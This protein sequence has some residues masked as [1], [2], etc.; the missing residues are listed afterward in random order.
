[1]QDGS[2]AANAHIW[3]QTR[4]TTVEVYY[5]FFMTSA[6]GAPDYTVGGNFGHFAYN[7]VVGYSEGIAFTQAPQRG[8]APFI[9]EA[10][11]L[12]HTQLPTIRSDSPAPVISHTQT[13]TV[14]PVHVIDPVNISI[15]KAESGIGML[16]VEFFH[17]K[18]GSVAWTSTVLHDNI[19]PLGSNLSLSNRIK[20]TG[21]LTADIPAS[22][23]DGFS[24]VEYFIR[25]TDVSRNRTDSPIYTINYITST[26]IPVIN[27]ASMSNGLLGASYNESLL[28]F[29][30]APFTWSIRDG[31]LPG[32]LSLNAET[33]AIS[34]MPS[35]A[36]TFRF[37]AEVENAYGTDAREY[38]IIIY[39]GSAFTS[40][41]PDLI[42]TGISSRNEFEPLGWGSASSMGGYSGQ[43][44][45]VFNT[46]SQSIN[47][48]EFEAYYAKSSQVWV[49]VNPITKYAEADIA[50]GK[51]E[52]EEAWLPAYSVGVIW[53]KQSYQGITATTRNKTSAEFAIQMGI[54]ESLLF[55]AENTVR[56]IADT[57]GHAQRFYLQ[58]NAEGTRNEIGLVKKGHVVQDGPKGANADIWARCRDAPPTKCTTPYSS[59][60][61]SAPPTFCPAA[62]TGILPTTPP[63]AT[64]RRS[65]LP[66]RRN[67]DS[68]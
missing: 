15:D 55:I 24:D 51:V 28:S 11:H 64:P 41:Y 48:K 59:R 3:A 19:F 2:K 12:R 30:A 14:V 61:P 54:D 47:L 46:T 68:R 37:T 53:I 62:I 36:G 34:G 18:A 5:A 67:W 21:A 42:I 26:D 32:G 65:P 1:M 16:T 7:P 66:S 58:N 39:D 57:G 29:G 8:Q 45:E 23:F 31:G 33:G 56:A 63:L 40:S 20:D 27:R 52:P 10:G 43:Y 13:V 60:P 35:E 6:V 38:T 9:S 25:A 17:R 50:V 44:I 22:V 49:A 4:C